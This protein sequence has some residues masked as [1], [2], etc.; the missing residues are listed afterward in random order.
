[1]SHDFFDHRHYVIVPYSAILNDVNF[2]QVLETSKNTVRISIDGTKGL[3][4]YNGPMPS[5]IINIINRS[6]EYTYEEIMQ[7]LHTEEWTVPNGE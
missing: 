5:S 3:V 4:K 7:I 1:M 6:E 2:D